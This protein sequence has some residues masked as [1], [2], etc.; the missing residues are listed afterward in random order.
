MSGQTPEATVSDAGPRAQQGKLRR[1]SGGEAGP[2]KPDVF[3]LPASESNVV[4]WRLIVFAV[5][6]A[7]IPAVA[8][9]GWTLN[10]P[11][12]ES[13]IPRSDPHEPGKRSLPV[14]DQ[15]RTDST[16]AEQLRDTR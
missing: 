8:L 11:S 2:A 10:V 1:R 5:I 12:L 16:G 7:A 6:S 4:T 13:G 14:G 15:R 3:G 9:L